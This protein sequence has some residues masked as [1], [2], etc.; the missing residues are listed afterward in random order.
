LTK[1]ST[2]PVTAGLN[3]PTGLVFDTDGTL[4][5]C[6]ANASNIEKYSSAGADQGSIGSLPAGSGALDIALLASGGQFEFSSGA[7]STSENAG[8]VTITVN[9][10]NGSRGATSVT[11]TTTDGTAKAGTDYKTTSGT[12]TWEDGDSASQSFTVPIIDRGITTGGS[13]AFGV[14]LT[15]P[16]SGTGTFGAPASATV[17]INDN[18]MAGVL[19]FSADAYTTFEDAGSV[20]VT[21]SRVDGSTGAV[22]VN[23]A[24][25]G[26]TAVVGTDYT[27][28][29][30]TLNWASGDMADKTFTVP[31]LDHGVTSGSV[32]FGVSL[33]DA[34]GTALGTPA[35]ASVTINDN[36]MASGGQIQ[37]SSAT[38]Q[39][40]QDAGSVTITI[41]RVDGA[42]G[43]TSVTYTT[44]D[45]TAQAG[46]DYTQ[47]SGTLNWADGD[48]AA[49]SFTVPIIDHGVTS[50]SVYFGVTF[51]TISG[52]ATI[53]TPASATVTITDNDMP[54]AGVLQFSASTYQ[55]YEDAGTASIT[56]SRTGGSN[57][58]VSVAYA[59]GGGTAKAGTDY[60]ATSGTLTWADG[61]ATAK[62]IAVPI[63]DRKITSATPGT[64]NVTLSA[65]TGDA[66]LGTPN[67]ATVS[68]SDNDA[69]TQPTVTLAYSQSATNLPGEP[70]NTI[71]VGTVLQFFADI[72]DPSN[73]L[74]QVQF[75]LDGALIGT[76]PNDDGLYAQSV[77]FPDRGTHTVEAIAT[78][79]QGGMS[80]SAATFTVYAEPTITYCTAPPSITIGDGQR[81][82]VFHRLSR[83]TVCLYVRRW[84]P[85]PWRRRELRIKLPHESRRLP[86]RGFR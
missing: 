7:Y 47:T 12:L 46:T 72:S 85:N 54:P 81:E 86:V 10:A 84:C 33:S 80:T 15:D 71:P 76:L 63:I 25:G 39:T 78:S 70:P 36:D 29:T 6:N 1:A 44:T 48:A 16:I 79:L 55:T 35:S 56:V 34:V 32:N 5:V 8:N 18:D 61:D 17:T 60:T 50:G 65:P 43:A 69:P 74:S 38:Y 83:R 9:R 42:S 67:P 75:T 77:T 22:S 73:Q 27:E 37:F 66:T 45:G 31:I 51:L 62:I 24:T 4:Y 11:Y 19:Q 58:T 28:T 23:Y 41:N 21:V 13:F 57:G 40:Y 2:P 20:M 64:F 26:G 52:L 82:G 49:K 3:E 53:G 14:A 59:T 68:I 30:G